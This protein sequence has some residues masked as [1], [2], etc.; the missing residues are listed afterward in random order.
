M[1]PT[2]RGLQFGMATLHG[3]CQGRNA[4]EHGG[5]EGSLALDSEPLYS[6]II[7]AYL[8]HAF[9][10]PPHSNV[11]R[12]YDVIGSPAMEILPFQMHVILLSQPCHANLDRPKLCSTMNAYY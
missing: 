3:G 12:L 4:Q 9:I 11:I 1:G 6:L 8:G 10:E 7:G 2:G 5:R